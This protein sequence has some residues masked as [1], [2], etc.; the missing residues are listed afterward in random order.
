MA[1]KLIIKRQEYYAHF[2]RGNELL[3]VFKE[4]VF[5]AS[6]DKTTWSDAIEYGKQLKIRDK[7]LDF[8]P[9][10]FENEDY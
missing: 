1:D 4:R 7:Q 8:V 3:I 10:R 5:A 2:Y 6:T 9:N